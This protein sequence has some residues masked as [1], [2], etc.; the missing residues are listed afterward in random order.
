M[1]TDQRTNQRT[2][3]PTNQHSELLRRLHGPKNG[4]DSFRN[5]ELFCT[6]SVTP[7]FGST[8]TRI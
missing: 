5:I 2:D 1:G 8:E 3:G 4:T 7:G 6:I